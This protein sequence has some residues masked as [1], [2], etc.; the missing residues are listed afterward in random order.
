LQGWR[1][2]V[3]LK[4]VL[5]IHAALQYISKYASKAEPRSES[6]SE[7]FNQILNNSEPDVSSVTSIQKL[8]LNGV[9]ERDISAQETCHLLLGTPLY[10]S[11]RIFVSLN[12]NEEGPRWIRGTGYGTNDEDFTKINEPGRTNQSP[13]KKYWDRSDEFE[14]ISLYKIYLTHINTRKELGKKTIMKVLFA[15]GLVHRDIVMEISGRN[16]AG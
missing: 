1:A 7:I 6:F 14:D 13:L 16:F 9:S 4:P 15:Y 10:H 3:D 8:L 12:L 5:S 11:S 2:N